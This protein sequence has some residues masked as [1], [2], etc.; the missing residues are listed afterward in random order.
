MLPSKVR[1]SIPITRDSH[2]G[3]KIKIIKA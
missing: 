2:C 1:F 3:K